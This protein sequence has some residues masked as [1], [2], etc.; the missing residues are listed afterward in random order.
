[1][2]GRVGSK[3][4]LSWDR[5]GDILRLDAVWP[6]CAPLEADFFDND[7]VALFNSETGALEGLEVLGFSRRFSALGDVLDL[8]V[9]AELLLDDP[10]PPA[11]EGS[12]A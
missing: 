2:E 1:M 12:A 9:I 4:R 6:H 7:V 5:D 11:N 8:P 10:H 3:L